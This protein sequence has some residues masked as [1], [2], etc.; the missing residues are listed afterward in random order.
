MI[1]GTKAALTEEQLLDR[2]EKGATWFEVHTNYEDIENLETTIEKISFKRNRV[3]N[4]LC[5]CTNV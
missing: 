5:S 4:I 2:R 3:K 1:V